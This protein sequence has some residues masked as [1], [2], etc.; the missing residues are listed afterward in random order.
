M[1]MKI[2]ELAFF[3]ICYLIFGNFASFSGVKFLVLFNKISHFL[4]HKRLSR[5]FSFSQVWYPRKCSFSGAYM[6]PGKCSLSAYNTLESVQFLGYDTQKVY[7]EYRGNLVTM[8]LFYQSFVARSV[9][10]FLSFRVL[11]IPSESESKFV[12]KSKKSP[13][14]RNKNWKY[15]IVWI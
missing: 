2:F 9:S 3:M 8:A 14:N 1:G 10:G 5:K 6:I 13:R 7:V 11:I 15:F 4:Q 12:E